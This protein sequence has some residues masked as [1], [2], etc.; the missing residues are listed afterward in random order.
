MYF[1]GLGAGALFA[2]IS[3]IVVSRGRYARIGMTVAMGLNILVINAK[4][5]A[6]IRVSVLS[7]EERLIAF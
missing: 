7:V 4:R 2:L 3:S 6:A 1:S 5:S